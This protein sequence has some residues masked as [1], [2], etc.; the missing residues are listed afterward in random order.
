MPNYPYRCLSCKR[1][2]ETF[3]SYSEYG[4]KPVACPH[5]GSSQ[6]QRRIVRVRVAKSEES[7]LD[8]FGDMSDLEG[9]ENDPQAMGS[10]M[11]KMSKEAGE[12]LGPEFNEVIDRLESGQSPEEI[13][14]SLPDL[15]GEMPGAGGEDDY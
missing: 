2:F 4:S 15:G 14:K 7:R 3:M 6:V 5:C 11:R 13:E 10:L 1:R 9:L 12:D 8:S